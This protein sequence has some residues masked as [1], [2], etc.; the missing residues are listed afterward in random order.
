[1]KR[2]RLMMTTLA[3]AGCLGVGGCGRETNSDAP[4]VISDGPPEVSADG[5]SHAS[6]GPHGGQ[7]I[8]L[9][10]EAYHAELSH[11]DA[12]HNVIVYLLDSTAAEPV[13]AADR[14]A[15]V[16][17]NLLL[18]GKPTQFKLLAKSDRYELASAAL[19]DALCSLDNSQARLSLTIAGRP[20]SGKIDAGEHGHTGHVHN[21]QH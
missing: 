16:R 19:C 10:R 5:H 3:C 12:T 8:E 9:G 2:I 15:E 21:H 17:I 7:L 11:D 6:A 1:M 18:A 13:A 20:F 14:P 4:I